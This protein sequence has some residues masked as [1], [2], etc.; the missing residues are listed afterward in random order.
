MSELRWHTTPEDNNSLKRDLLK[1]PTSAHPHHHH[2]HHHHH[3][4][5]H[6]R[7]K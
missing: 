5:M 7:C 6:N 4:I 2:H 3:H 1:T